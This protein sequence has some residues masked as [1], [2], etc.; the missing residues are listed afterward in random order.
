MLQW[1]RRRVRELEGADLDGFVF[2]DGSPSCGMDQVRIYG[3]H[4]K[5]RATSKGQGIFARVFMKHFPL[6]PVEGDGRIQVPLFRENFIER[7]LV[8]KQWRDVLRR[9]RRSRAELA[10]FHI[11][12]E[13]LILSHSLRHYRIMGE[14]VARP[15]AMS[16]AALSAEYQRLLMDAL[17][18]KA[19]PAKHVNVLRHIAGFFKKQL[20]RDERQGL[21]DVI[22][23]Y[24]RG[25]ASLTVPI[26]LINH[27]ARLFDN[28]FLKGQRYLY[29]LNLQHEVR[30]PV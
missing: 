16:M 6:I 9:Y 18:L 8:M 23:C 26:D 24:R 27:Y 3:T 11:E 28:A 19:T 2:K 15:K 10:R 17:R 20:S 30:D 7:C 29:P 21:R 4:K 14:L 22:D 25:E 1:A 12:H 13:L 5:K